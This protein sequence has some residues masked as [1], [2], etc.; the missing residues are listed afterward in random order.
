MAKIKEKR[1]RKHMVR[2]D[3]CNFIAELCSMFIATDMGSKVVK[4]VPVLAVIE[5]NCK[6]MGQINLHAS[7]CE[8]QST[9]LFHF[10]YSTCVS[11]ELCMVE[12]R[13]GSYVVTF[14]Y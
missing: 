7:Y 5:R 11:F 14:K 10:G 2:L 6:K 12:F 4:F 1:K 8:R 9:S 3:L 13:S